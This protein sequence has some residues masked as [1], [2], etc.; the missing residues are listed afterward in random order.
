MYQIAICDDEEKILYDMQKKIEN[1]FVSQGIEAEYFCTTDSEKMLEHIKEESVDVLFLDID[2]PHISGMDIASYL[3]ENKP[4]VLFVFVTSQEALVYQSFAYRPFGFVRKTHVDA[5]LE[6]LVIRI[7]RELGE[8]RQE[9]T[10]TKGQ[11]LIRVVKQ[12]IIYIEA[13]GNYLNLCTKQEML[14]VR[15]T[16][17]NM[18]NELKENG[19]VRCHKGYLVN[20]HLIEKT[21]GAQIE[22]RGETQKHIVPIGRSYEKDVKKKILELI[23]K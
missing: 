9:L 4:E 2:M 3:K 19:F 7:K 20:A 8:K 15:D 17:T 14:K 5:E 11:E 10:I 16:M 18:E 1:C 22:L 23:R 13:E 12:E 21:K 6:E